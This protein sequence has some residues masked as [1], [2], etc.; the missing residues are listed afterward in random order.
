[1]NNIRLLPVVIVVVGALFVLKT[2][3]L[4]TQG[5]YVLSG[6]TPVAVVQDGTLPG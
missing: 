1:M 6:T 3:G 5:H 2:T 4:V